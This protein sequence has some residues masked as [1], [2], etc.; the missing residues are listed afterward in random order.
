M[1]YRAFQLFCDGELFGDGRSHVPMPLRTGA[2][3]VLQFS[4]DGVGVRAL[5]REHDSGRDGSVD[6]STLVAVLADAGVRLS[7]QEETCVVVSIVISPAGFR[8]LLRHVW[9]LLVWCLRVL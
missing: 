4:A 5:L 9:L 1:L 8:V 7:R 2:A 6:L 3:S